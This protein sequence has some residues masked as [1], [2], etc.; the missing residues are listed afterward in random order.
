MK[1]FHRVFKSLKK[2][3]GYFKILIYFK[4]F[5]N[6]YYISKKLNIIQDKYIFWSM[7]F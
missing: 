2:V 6:N 7:L 3:N 1:F 5:K 4:Y